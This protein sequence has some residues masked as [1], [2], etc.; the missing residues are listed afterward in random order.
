MN[1][2]SVFYPQSIAVVGASTKTGSVGNDLVKN[3]VKQG[4]EGKIYPVNPKTDRLFDLPCYPTLTAIGQK[5]ELAIIAIPAAG[6]PAI[7]EECGSLKIRGAIVI[8][9]G[10]KEIGNTELEN[11][12]LAICQKHDIALIGPN[13]LGVINSEIQMNASFAMVMPHAGSV[14]FV[15]QS[16][17][18]CTAVL[19]RANKMGIGFSKFVSVGNK[20]LI[21]ELSLFKYFQSDP[22]TKVIVLYVEQLT[23]A[24][25]LIAAAKAI[26]QSA[27]NPK[28]ILV[29][30]AGKTAAG[31]SA[32][33]SHTGA[34]AGNDA[35]YD[36]LFRQS[37]ILR[38][39]GTAELFDRVQ[40]FDNNDLPR[41]RRVAIIT[42]AG[43]PGVLTTDAVIEQGLTLAQL[44][45]RTIEGLKAILPPAAATHNPVDLLGDAKADRYQA[46]LRLVS[47]DPNVD[48]LMVILTPQSMTEFDA[49]AQAIVE[50]HNESEKPFMVS[51]MGDS[52]VK[53]AVRILREGGI[54]SFAYPE[55]AI[56]SLRLLCDFQE[57]SKADENLVPTFSDVDRKTVAKIF[58]K[59][60]AG[61][62]TMFPEADALEILSA[63]KFPLLPRQVVHSA[64]EAIKVGK[65]IS[66]PL[67]LKIES[68][69]ILHKTDAG[70]I[71]LNVKPE[72]AGDEYEA[73]ITRIA[74]KFPKAK[75]DG[76]LLM[77]MAPLGGLE[78]I[79]GANRD[80]QFGPLVMYGL[81]G[82]YVEALKD[83]TFGLA[84][85][86]AYDARTMMGLVR[87]K[88]LYSGIRGGAPLDQEK[89]LEMLGRLSQ[90]VTD[91][92]QIREIDINPLLML[93]KGDGVRVLDARI[94]ID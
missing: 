52:T 63:Y 82:I 27:K 46:A 37:G 11:Q 81:G 94:V 41:G 53:S 26:T 65:A 2:D 29:L 85:L 93:P 70:G 49:T 54:A 74:A 6:V 18:L 5:V 14:A 83:V 71:S 16:G 75:I 28:P 21:N 40:A 78:L 79:L 80:P 34:L 10:F 51:F 50:A 25:K 39:A 38:V 48:N 84:P 73:M 32:S 13:C 19:D 87:C 56:A 45:P 44:D 62:K 91:F 60:K 58:D 8:S 69:D 68:Q 67:A 61:G 20:A 33:A 64:K 17:A 43:G 3:L 4:F 72:D 47:L 30:K 66:K 1:L 12:L 77:E 89:V 86:T 7:L 36:A 24:Q 31:A 55:K 35:A 22:K 59:A 57:W 9:A 76:V 92:P 15:S 42:N 90:L 23:D 88:G